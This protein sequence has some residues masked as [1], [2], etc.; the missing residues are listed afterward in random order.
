[1]G[2]GWDIRFA[3][4]G[5]SVFTPWYAY[6]VDGA[7]WRVSTLVQHASCSRPRAERP[8]G[9]GSMRRDGRFPPGGAVPPESGDSRS[10]HLAIVARSAPAA[11]CRSNVRSG[12]LRMPIWPVCGRD[13]A[14]LGIWLVQSKIMRL[15]FQDF[16]VIVMN[17]FACPHAALLQI[18]V[19]IGL[20]K[21]QTA[22]MGR[23]AEGLSRGM[24]RGAWLPR[25]VL[26]ALGC[27]SGEPVWLR[28]LRLAARER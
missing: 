14:T 25:M 23:K 12:S 5:V 8:A 18:G 24:N 6:D 26:V 1:M 3:H 28:Y 19:G 9:S 15:S 27:D 11:L 20:S 22:W 16:H 21:R 4:Q 2:S 7:R 17:V 13:L 10:P